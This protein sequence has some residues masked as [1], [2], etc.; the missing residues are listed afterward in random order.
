MYAV[1]RLFIRGDCVF[2][3]KYYRVNMLIFCVCFRGLGEEGWEEA[4][5]KFDAHKMIIFCS[6][7]GGLI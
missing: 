6:T 5:W 1:P 3:W 7:I 4:T 2:S